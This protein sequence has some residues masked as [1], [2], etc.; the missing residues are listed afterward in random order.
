VIHYVKAQPPAGARTALVKYL[1]NSPNPG[2]TGHGQSIYSVRMEAN[3]KVA[4]PAFKPM[5]VTFTWLE[6]QEDYSTVKRSHTQ[7]VEHVPFT[8]TINVGGADHPVME[9]LRTNLKGAVEGV[10]YGY[11]D[12]RDVGGEKFVGRWVSVGKVLSTGKPYTCTVPSGTYRGAGDPDGKKL[13]DGI[14][15]PTY[16]GGSA[17][18]WSAIWPKGTTPAITVD[19]GQPTSCGAFRID[20]GGSPFQ[21]G[22]LGQVKDKVEVLVSSDNKQYASVGFFDFKLRWK[23][24]PA[25]YAWND[26]ETFNE[27]NYS[28]IPAQ[29][30]EARY[31]RFALTPSRMMTVS[32][33]QVLDSIKYAP[34]DLKIALPDGQD[35]SDIT[36]YNPKHTPS[37]PR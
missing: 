5:E 22:V 15:G 32:E 36:Q 2:G 4:E 24:I 14:V 3:Y 1:M 16:A 20:V 21:D 12:G 28:L 34:F 33:V 9:S 18:R 17:Y 37:H 29:R 7:L 25:N 8:Y 19:L 23:D 11:S 6:R 13:T 26:E 35:R 30:V 27:Y 10:R 31:V